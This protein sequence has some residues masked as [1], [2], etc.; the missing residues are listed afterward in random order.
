MVLHIVMQ[1]LKNL[2]SKHLR[3]TPGAVAGFLLGSVYQTLALYAKCSVEIVRNKKK[4]NK[5]QSNE[6]K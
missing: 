2:Q 5:K 3:P 1:W 6:K 4:F